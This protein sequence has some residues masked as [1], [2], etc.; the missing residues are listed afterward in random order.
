MIDY[1]NFYFQ[2]DNFNSIAQPFYVLLD[3]RDS[4]MTPLSYP[5]AYDTNIENF[6]DF[7]NKGKEKYKSN[8]GSK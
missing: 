6:I 3:P 5:K 4:T 1:Q 2:K 8:H 7:L